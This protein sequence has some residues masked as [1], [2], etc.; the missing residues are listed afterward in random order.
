MSSRNLVRKTA[1]DVNICNI[2]ILLGANIVLKYFVE[3]E[4]C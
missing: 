1:E 3:V 2:E 4:K